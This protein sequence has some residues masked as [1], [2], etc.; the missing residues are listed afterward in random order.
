M[1]VFPGALL[2]DTMHLTAAEFGAYCMILF[3]TWNNNGV[4]LPDDD[5]RLARITRLSLKAWRKARPTLAQFFDLSNGTWLQKRLQK[6][7]DYVAQKR[8]VLSKVGTLG[9]EAKALKRNNTTLANAIPNGNAHIPKRKNPS[10]VEVNAREARSLPIGAL[11]SRLAIR[12][13]ADLKAREKP[14]QQ[15]A[16]SEGSPDDKPHATPSQPSAEQKKHPP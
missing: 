13:E 16:A 5:A 12:R 15:P 4:P 3:V 6:E 11:A 7:W 14:V 2:G 9:N 1:P 10:D 8:I